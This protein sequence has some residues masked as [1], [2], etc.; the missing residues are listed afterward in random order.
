MG[1]AFVDARDVASAAAKI[2]MLPGDVFS[3]FAEVGAIEVH[4]PEPVNLVENVSALS[5]AVGY[6][7]ALKTVPADR[8][9]DAMVRYGIERVHAKSLCSTIQMTAG[10]AELEG[11]SELVS[12]SSTLLKD[13]TGWTPQYTVNDWAN[14][15][16]VLKLLKKQ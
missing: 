6:D 11:S 12:E 9:I 14:S 3:K 15:T 8:W 5:D 10:D 16:K 7:I 4:G 2:L 1:G 13:F